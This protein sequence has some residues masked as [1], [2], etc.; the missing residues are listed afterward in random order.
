MT[1]QL[2]KITVDVP[3]P[4]LIL[5]PTEIGERIAHYYAAKESFDYFCTY[6]CGY[7]QSAFQKEWDQFIDTY[8]RICL[9]ATRDHAKTTTIAVLKPL[10]YLTFNPH[11]LYR[12]YS[13]NK[14][15]TRRLIMK[16]IDSFTELPFFQ[17]SIVHR[18]NNKTIDLMKY[19]KQKTL[20]K[21]SKME[22]TFGN[23]SLVIGEGYPSA[24][25]GAHPDLIVLDD[26]LTDKT[27]ITDEMIKDI[28][29]EAISPM[30]KLRTGKIIVVGTPQHYQDLLHELFENPV[31][32]SKKY[33]IIVDESK[34]QILWPE[35]WTW[36]L[37]QEKKLEVGS[38]RF[39]KEYMCNPLRNDAA[40]I[41]YPMIKENCFEYTTVLGLE[42]NENSV[43]VI[44]CDLA[45]GENPESSWSVTTVLELTEKEGKKHLRIAE[46]D[47][48]KLGY[49]QQ[50][51]RVSTLDAKYK[52]ELLYV[53]NNS[54][55]KIFVQLLAD[56]HYTMPI[57]GVKTGSEK[58]NQEIGIPS[59]KQL[60]ENQTLIIPRGDEYSIEQTNILIE[61]LCAFYEDKGRVKTAAPHDDCVLS[62]WIALKAAREYES[63]AFW[64]ED[65]EE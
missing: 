12:T 26:I 20:G 42:R 13:C 32:H 16:K 9:M 29:F 40:L 15:E 51:M 62:L 5:Q 43:Y 46:L 53:E 59:L 21:W 3:R 6:C 50:L 4:D 57:E 63:K 7:P 36:E 65:L 31:Y 39:S 41:S 44:G 58:H 34:E 52:P 14:A 60:I 25:R 17:D 38:L 54:F 2:Q 37:V 61:E 8:N 1:I 35:R 30:S 18:F 24:R 22:M 11:F 56:G 19:K 48:Y 47:R 27:I 49:K 64:F 33:P 55:Q 45:I 23:E 10:H 28:F